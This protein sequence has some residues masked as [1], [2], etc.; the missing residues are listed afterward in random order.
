MLAYDLF[1]LNPTGHHMVNLLFHVA[2]TLLL[3]HLLQRMTGA[4]WRSGFVAAL[5]ALHPPH[6][7][8]V[9]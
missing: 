8:S 7:E 4:S 1:G 3:F 6:V 2:N 5:F 9:A